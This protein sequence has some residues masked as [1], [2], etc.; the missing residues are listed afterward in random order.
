MISW[1]SHRTQNFL[2]VCR[3]HEIRGKHFHLLN[4]RRTSKISKEKNPANE[5]S[6]LIQNIFQDEAPEEKHV[7][8]DDSILKLLCPTYGTLLA[9]PKVRLYPQRQAERQLVQPHLQ[10]SALWSLN[11]PA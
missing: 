11:V 5:P 8:Q 3:T 10:S 4:K 1:G 2:N 7:I 6:R 9:D